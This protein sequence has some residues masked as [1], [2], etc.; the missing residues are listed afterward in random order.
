MSRTLTHLLDRTASIERKTLTA[1]G[2]GQWQET[3][4]IIATG[5]RYRRWPAGAREEELGAAI[6]LE[7]SHKAAFGPDVVV[8][9]G[10][11]VIDAIGGERYE[12]QRVHGAPKDHHVEVWLLERQLEAAT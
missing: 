1:A 6:G 3:P 9:R 8:R 10:D 2:G 7:V 12:V 4:G 5:V 11:Y